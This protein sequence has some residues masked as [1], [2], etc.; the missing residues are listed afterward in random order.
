MDIAQ[1]IVERLTEHPSEGI[2][3][4][5]GVGWLIKLLVGTVIKYRQKEVE[6]KEE[7]DDEQTEAILRVKARV[8]EL[9]TNQK[10]ALK[11]I[12]YIQER[13]SKLEE[14]PPK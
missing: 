4:V 3:L 8:T 9:E 5:I 7:M 13:V 11:D 2:L 14:I 6:A 10:L 1:L 12:E